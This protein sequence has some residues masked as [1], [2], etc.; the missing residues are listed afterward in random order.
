MVSWTYVLRHVLHALST[1]VFVL[2]FNFFL[3]RL[4]GDPVTLLT[5]SSLHLDPKE[6]AALRDELGI[7]DPVPIQFVNYMSDTVTGELGQSFSSGR[8][9]SEVVGARLWPTI[10]L[11]GTATLFSTVIG[12]WVGIRGP[13]DAGAHST[14]LRSSVRSSS[15]RCRRAGWA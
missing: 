2:A 12:L 14:R 15:I 5:R 11:V 7:G 10:L 3:F 1:L 13:G 4:V 6:Q 9:V 8:P